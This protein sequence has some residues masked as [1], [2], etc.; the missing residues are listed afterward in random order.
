MRDESGA[1][2]VELGLVIGI[3][4]F[5]LFGL[6]DFA[7]LGFSNVMAEKATATAVRM[8]TV[9]PAICSGVPSVTQRSLLGTLA[10]TTPNGTRCSA[11]SGLCSPVEEVTCTAAE[12]GTD[13]NAIWARVRPLLPGN[14]EP[15]NLR[16]TYSYDEDLNRVGA[17]YSP[18][19]TAE[20]DGLEF[21][22]ISPL[23]ALAEFAGASGQSGL[24]QSFTFASMSA[25][26]PAEDLR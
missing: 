20:I 22:F 24:G 23:G 7:R 3:F 1:T 15:E 6:I 16:F 5:L 17:P 14:A 11:M 8:A 9:R 25:S 13:A 4:L 19:V 26:L 18:I 2:L 12:G 21:N 10:L